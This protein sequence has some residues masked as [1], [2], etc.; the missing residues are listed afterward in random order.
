MSDTF[1]RII[2]YNPERNSITINFTDSG[3]VRVLDLTLPARIDILG[4]VK[5]F[6]DLRILP[7]DSENDA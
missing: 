7:R 2:R 5:V 3:G 6:Q 1:L 4:D